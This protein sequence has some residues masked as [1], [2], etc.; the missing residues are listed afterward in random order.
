MDYKLWFRYHETRS[1]GEV[2]EGQENDSW[3]SYEYEYI[4]FLPVGLYKDHPDYTFCHGLMNDEVN[5]EF[6]RG[7]DAYIVIARYSDGDTFTHTNGYW[8]IIGVYKTADEAHDVSESI[9]RREYDGMRHLP[10]H[11]YFSSFE[12]VDTHY[13]KVL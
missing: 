2:C 13:M 8:V 12:N 11:G 1:G 6:E 10:W 5:G 9:N 7:D 4:D 3:P